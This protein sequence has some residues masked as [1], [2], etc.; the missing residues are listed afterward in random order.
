[1][2][3]RAR[4][5]ANASTGRR[6]MPSLL[7]PLARS[8]AE[9]LHTSRVRPSH[10]HRA[11]NKPS[12][13][14]GT[15]NV[16][17]LVNAEGS[18]E[19]ARQGRDVCS[20]EDRKIDL[21][22]HVLKRYDVKVAA[23]QETLW[24]GSAVYHVGESVVL[25]AGRPVQAVGKPRKR[26]E[27]VA[28]VLDGPA[29]IAWRA[30]GQ[31]WKAWSS[32][33][34]STQLQFGSRRADHLHVLSCY[35]PTRAASRVTKDEFFQDLERALSS[36]PSVAPYILLGDF[37]ARVGSRTGAHDLW[38]GV[39]GPD[40]YGETNDAGR[41][42]LAFLAAQGATVC[43]TWFQKRDIYKQTWQHPKSKAWH[44]IDLAIMRQRD[45][46]RCLDVAVKRGA[47]CHTDHQLLCVK[48]R[49]SRKVYHRRITAT[50]ARRFN[51]SRLAR[52]ENEDHSEPTQRSMFQEQ[53]TDRAAA[54][55]P[56]GGSVEEK[57]E[58]VRS[59]LTKSA[60]AL[61]GMEARCHPDWFRENADRLKP[62]LQRRNDLYTTWLATRGADALSQFRRARGECR[63]TIRE[64]KNRWFQ[65][66]AEEAQRERF[67]GK[68]VWR[69]IRD[70]QH[71]RRGLVP[72][73]S[74]TINDEEG[75]PCTSPQAQQ[76]RWRRHFT[77]V[78]NLQ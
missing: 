19:T 2:A 62:A 67:G 72:S 38:D 24:F 4:S 65:T 11:K 75:N 61:L 77:T 59:T 30:A 3:L 45:R 7:S 27:G 56:S 44:C 15:W 70:M 32:R 40:G 25:A 57:W 9:E 41:E 53:V 78:L 17:S 1:M 13:R 58:A 36:I 12:W 5:S 20:A 48:M 10:A 8:P 51:V 50:R 33:L 54:E 46:R 37:N 23:L 22:V 21:V 43:N 74:A 16:R 34:V 64:A 35:V 29:I 63:R 49:M 14:L 73:R 28:I 42:L 47:E 68:K 39:R 60:E 26:G 52:G 6:S 18:V 71:G 69:C 55:W 31:Q 76:Q 66:K